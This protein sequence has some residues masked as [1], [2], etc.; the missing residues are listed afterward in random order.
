MKRK[1]INHISR[2]VVMLAL[3][4]TATTSCKKDLE[5]KYL[6]PDGFTDPTIEGFFSNAQV[7][8]GV[9]RYSYGEFYHTFRA[10][11]G[12]LGSGGYAN[13]GAANTFGWGH[14]PYGDFYGKLRSI[15]AMSDVYAKLPE[16]DKTEYQ[17]FMWTGNVI[18]DYIFYHLTD[19]CGDVPYTDAMQAQQGNF[20]PK[21]DKQKDIYLSILADLKDVSGK[22]KG[23]TLGSTAIQKQ[24]L[25]NDVWFAGDVAKWRSFTN[26][27]RLRL[28]MRISVVEPELAKT[29]IQEVL[30]DGAYATN[31]ATSVTLV[32][33]EQDR[34]FEYL[35]NRSLQ[36]SRGNL[37]MP[38][39]MAKVMRKAGQ[40]DDPRIKVLFQPDKD[41]NYSFMPT[42]A[43]DVSV[44][45]P[46]ITSTDLSKTYPSI[47]NRSTFEMN[48]GMM[49]LIITS[50]EIHLIKAEAG[51]RWPELGIDVANEYKLAIQESIDIYYE[52]N[53]LNTNK[54]YAGYIP[55]SM[56]AKPDQAVIE[57]FL[58]AKVAEF[59]IAN[60]MEKKGL[61]F[62]QKYIHFN[63][64]K[65]Y[66]LWSDTRRLTKELGARVKKSP[67]NIKLME[68]TVYPN[69][70]ELNN[71]TNFQAVK[72]QNNYTTP[73]WWTGR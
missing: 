5:G 16:A 8:L 28:A 56:P 65:P 60:D 10:F 14:S 30:A 36:E 48:V 57:A 50:S 69:S 25:I 35:L 70:E 7:Q 67:S 49:A 32:D 13:D 6:N 18:K 46:N 53:A 59:T 22:L 2:L 27:L 72:A 43:N 11:N 54:T 44:I 71:N 58:A 45:R 15:K 3:I 52:E 64:L 55:A 37:W 31:R 41:G 42:E 20:F 34:A 66:E 26:S 29:T 24:F 4:A 23:F 1:Y 12:I 63:M 62:D 38:E 33:R 21:F 51:L 73:M 19:D 17:I 68:R 61:V 39:N 47:Y 40:P 9:F